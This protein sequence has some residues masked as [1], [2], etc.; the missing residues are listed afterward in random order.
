MTKSITEVKPVRNAK[1]SSPTGTIHC[2]DCLEVLRKLP[3]ESVDLT[4]F[5]PPYDGIRDYNG[6]WNLDFAGLG[7]ELLRVSK[8]GAV[9]A[10]VIGDG[11]KNFAKSLTTFRWAVQWVDTAGWK[12]F[13]CCIYAR[14]GNPGAWWSKRFR[15]DHEYILIF[16]KGTRPKF[17]D[18]QHLMIDSKHAGKIYSGT[19]R[20]TSGGFKKI[21][22]KAVNPKKC[23]GTIWNYATS[24]TEGNRTKLLHPATY[25]DKLAEDLILC[26]SEEGDTILDPMCGSGTTAVVAANN[27]RNYVGIEINQ[28]YVEIIQKRIE[29]EVD[30][31]NK[32]F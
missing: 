11:T 2:G 6:E 32:L 16:F 9:A 17:F 31:A 4:V 3:D 27:R 10:V 30:V 18:K 8:E 28:E 21:D 22:P 13:E 19:D 23:R 12:L 7:S 14:H 24:N 29:D 15:V 26:F 1:S 25:P 5:S 20:L